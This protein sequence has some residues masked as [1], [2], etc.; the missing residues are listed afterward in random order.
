MPTLVG[1]PCSERHKV[2]W[3]NGPPFCP[4]AFEYLAELN[5]LFFLSCHFYTTKNVGDRELDMDSHHAVMMRRRHNGKVNITNKLTYAFQAGDHDK[6]LRCVTTGPWLNK[7][8]VQEAFARLYVVCEFISFLV[9]VTT[10]NQ[11]CLLF[12]SSQSS[13]TA[14][15]R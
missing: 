3:W 1:R 2:V 12:R 8:D 15:K 4:L 10:C 6:L 13:P 5:F 11:Q 9:I 7:D 14:A